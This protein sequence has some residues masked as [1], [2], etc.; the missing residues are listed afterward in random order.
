MLRERIPNNCLEHWPGSLRAVRTDCPLACSEYV[1]FMTQSLSVLK[2]QST[3]PG[4]SISDRDS[5]GEKHTQM[6]QSFYRERVFTGTFILILSLMFCVEHYHEFRFRDTKRKRG[7]KW[8]DI[9][10]QTDKQKT[11]ECELMREN[12]VTALIHHSLQSP[13]RPHPIHQHLLLY[14]MQKVSG[15][16]M[17]CQLGPVRWLNSEECLKRVRS[18]PS[19]ECSYTGHSE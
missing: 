19:M 17:W 8:G 10:T 4:S 13:P 11:P 12:E 7:Q 9:T 15:M 2:R 6:L 5:R 18:R 1:N 16:Y 3:A 14:F